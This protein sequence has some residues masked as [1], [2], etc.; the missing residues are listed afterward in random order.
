MYYLF[1]L[2]KFLASLFPRWFCYLFAR[3]L[4][5]LHYHLSRKDRE[6]V[7]YN[8]LPA[9]KDK[10]K[11]EFNGCVRDVFVNFSYYL[12]DFFRYS[13]LND[14]FVKKYVKVSGLD[15]LN[16]AIS[17]DRGVIIVTAHLGNYE[18]AGVIT[19]LLGHSPYV[20][21][22]PHKDK[23][24]NRLFDKQREMFGL[25]VISTGAAIKGCFVALKKKQMVAFL[26]DRD[27]S[28]KGIKMEMFSREA[29]LPRG[30]AFFALKTGAVI[31]PVFLVREREKYYHMIFEKHIDFDAEKDCEE[32]VIKKYIPVLE[33]YIKKY[34]QQWY[35]FGKYWV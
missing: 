30:P 1:V 7:S 17:M 10:D 27:F 15:K 31:I 35:M 24:T 21:A 5:V 2:G 23:R 3:M 20:V 34:P 12:V 11:K 33:G 18:L 25:K 29:Y 14:A 9:I 13:K 32:D 6:I 19:A 8:L 4:A 16:K 22:L 28:G 26:G